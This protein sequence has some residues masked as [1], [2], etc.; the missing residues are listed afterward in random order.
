MIAESSK[1]GEKVIK[2]TL[3]ECC[4]EKMIGKQVWWYQS[5]KENK[6]S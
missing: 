2:G 5:I 6:M 1:V 3:S 4:M